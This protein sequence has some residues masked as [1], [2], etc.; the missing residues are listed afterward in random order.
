MELWPTDRPV[1]FSCRIILHYVECLCIILVEV[2]G[3]REMTW[4]SGNRRFSTRWVDPA[5]SQLLRRSL[6]T[7][8]G[9]HPWR[10]EPPLASPIGTGG[11]RTVNPSIPSHARYHWAKHT[12][13]LCGHFMSTFDVIIGVPLLSRSVTLSSFGKDLRSPK[14]LRRL[15]CILYIVFSRFSKTVIYSVFYIF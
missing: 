8:T 4:N 6:D 5:R 1:E 12:I 15:T 7:P 2:S 14:R 13:L 9:K 11:T 3:W 10:L